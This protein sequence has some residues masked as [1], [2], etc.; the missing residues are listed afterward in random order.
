MANDR[1][2]I[3]DA[4]REA[5]A[6]DLGEHFAMGRVTSEEYGER[7]DRI[8]AARTQ[9]ELSPVFGDL[10]QPRQLEP[11]RT[12][13]RGLSRVRARGWPPHVPFLL[14]VLVAI[15]VVAFAV[16]H[17]PLLILGLLLYVL[18]VRRG[19]H[20]HPGSARWR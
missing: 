3:G 4:E 17:L 15:V 6:H 19:W 5:A 9:G 20:R 8:Y 2:R 12:G 1:L 13:S 7:L 18:V 11:A 16:A 10:P 14:K